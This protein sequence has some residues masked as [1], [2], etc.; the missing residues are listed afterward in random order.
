MKLAFSAITGG[1]SILFIGLVLEFLDVTGMC[2]RTGYW[3]LQKLDSLFYA[4]H[5]E[6]NVIIV[7]AAC[8]FFIGLVLGLITGTISMSIRGKN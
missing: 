1:V 2:N 5:S 6:S 3:H 8:N 7:A 4:L